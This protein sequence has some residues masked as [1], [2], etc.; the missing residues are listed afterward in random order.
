[1]CVGQQSK[2]FRAQDG[3]ESLAFG[4][5]IEGRLNS[6]VHLRDKNKKYLR[7]K[8]PYVDIELNK[9]EYLLGE[10]RKAGFIKDLILEHHC[11]KEL[12]T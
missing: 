12:E 4:L 2:H 8:P 7:K 9:C 1:V 6:M 5:G 11:E 3:K 10:I